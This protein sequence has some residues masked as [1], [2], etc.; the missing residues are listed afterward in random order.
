MTKPLMT[1]SPPILSRT[2]PRRPTRRRGSLYLPVLLVGSIVTALAIGGL[3]VT[4]STARTASL[5]TDLAQARF[6]AASGIEAARAYIAS[7][8]NWRTLRADGVLYNATAFAA[9]TARFSVTAENPLG[10]LNRTSLDPVTITS[11]GTAGVANHTLTAT[12]APLNIQ[13][14]TCLNPTVAAASGIHFDS[15]TVL[16]RKQLIATNGAITTSLLGNS[17]EP[18]VEATLT[19][20]GLGFSGSIAILSPAETYPAGDVFSWYTAVGTAM[21]Y[22]SLPG[23]S[24]NRILT[25]TLISPLHNPFGQPHPHG[26]YMI[27]CA[28]GQ[29]TI[30]NTRI[31]GTLIVLNASQVTLSGSVTW[32]PA[33]GDLPAL[34]VQGPLAWRT[35]NTNLREVD[36][37]VNYN[38]PGVPFP[39]H[40]TAADNSASGQTAS[41]I[42]GLVYA[43]GNI[44]FAESPVLHSAVSGGSI[45]FGGTVTLARNDD[46]N[47]TSPPPG[48]FTFDFGLLPGSYR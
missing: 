7:T 4:R 44:I 13:P 24:G 10:P 18:D 21:A 29:L 14:L 35:T 30:S 37:S 39:Y 9:G 3:L 25:R 6:A 47:L 31:V 28:G 40:G 42:N 12:F 45:T 46:R 32:E 26:I 1:H 16:G 43:S 38:P 22:N 19:V 17:V 23:S 41:F 8:P 15:A 34:L 5:R 27:D 33:R 2:A 36:G 48:F 20:T 11:V